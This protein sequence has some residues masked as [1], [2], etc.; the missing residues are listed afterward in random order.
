MTDKNPIGP[1][2]ERNWNVDNLDPGVR[3]LVTGLRKLGIPTTDSG[4]G[5]SKPKLDGVLDFPHAFACYTAFTDCGR[6]FAMDQAAR[7]ADLL[8]EVLPELP[9][10]EGRIEVSWDAYGDTVVLAVI[11]W[12]DDDLAGIDWD[13][14]APKPAEPVK[15]AVFV[16]SPH[17]ALA[18]ASVLR[19]KLHEISQDHPWRPDFQE[20]ADVLQNGGESTARDILGDFRA[21]LGHDRDDINIGFAEMIEEVDDL[22]DKV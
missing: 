9:E 6:G 1:M 7:H 19:D 22:T 13:A 14:V 21:A 10:G 15:Q 20:A 4:D 8:R 16:M 3:Q 12:N 17:A 2:N 18:S 5:V 11:G